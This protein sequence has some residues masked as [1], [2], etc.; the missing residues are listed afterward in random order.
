MGIKMETVLTDERDERFIYLSNEL[1]NE[2]L[3]NIGEDALKYKE[4]NTLEDPHIVLLLLNWGNPIACASYRILDSESIEIRRVFVKRRYRKRNIAYKLV[5][6][7][8]KL[9]MENNF[10]YS[11][12]VTGTE[13]T[14]S[15]GLYKKL[16]YEK[17]DNF[18]FFKDDDACI[19]M[20]KE[21]K[22]LI[23]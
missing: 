15:I 5:K 19:C 1:D 18:G 11:Y 22:S 16:G 2:Y 9:A 17:I 4:Y 12:L 8:E 6:A 21:F 7:L 13:N 14:A 10:R 3:R 20:K 23:F